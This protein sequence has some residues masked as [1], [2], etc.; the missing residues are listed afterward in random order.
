MVALYNI[1][2]FFFKNRAPSSWFRYSQERRE[3]K[4]GTLKLCYFPADAVKPGRLGMS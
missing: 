3:G 2:F 1:Q 4:G